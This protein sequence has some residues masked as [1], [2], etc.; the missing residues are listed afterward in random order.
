MK[1]LYVLGLASALA[2]AGC[3]THVNKPETTENPAPAVRFNEYSKFELKPINEGRG[4]EKQHGGDKLLDS[5]NERLQKQLGKTLDSW[6]QSAE[7]KRAKRGTLVIEPVCS[8]AKLVG[9]TARIFLGPMM[10]SSAVVLSV[11]YTEARSG[12]LIAEP[13][14]YQRTAAMS[15]GFTFGAMDKN[16]LSRIV[17][18]IS[19]YTVN[20]YADL[21]GGRTGVE[22]EG[23]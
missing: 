21:V 9:T 5:V 4:C 3:A 1:K 19:D 20:N 11:R 13:V 15:G 23:G 17:T 6:E 2:A 10:G 7:A 16:M 14:F 18:L 22:K 8:D 12:K